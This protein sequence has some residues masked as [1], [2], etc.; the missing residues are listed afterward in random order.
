MRIAWCCGMERSKGSNANYDLGQPGDRMGA[1]PNTA[2]IG[3]PMAFA[4]IPSENCSAVSI[5]A[6]SGSDLRGGQRGRGAPPSVG[7]AALSLRRSTP[8]RT[9]NPRL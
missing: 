7:A 8:G 9:H 5:L 6:I 3:V 4:T 2:I 1:P